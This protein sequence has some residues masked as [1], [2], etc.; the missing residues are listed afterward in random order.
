MQQNKKQFEKATQKI[1][2]LK[3]ENKTLHEQLKKVRNFFITG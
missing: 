1:R 3:V 2:E